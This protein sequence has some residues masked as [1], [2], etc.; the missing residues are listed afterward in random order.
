M[1]SEIKINDEVKIIMTRD[2]FGYEDVLETLDD[3]EFV[4]IVTYN[5]SKE[6]DDLIKK[7]EAFPVDKDVIIITNIPG[8]F[9]TYTSSF[10]RKKAKD[11]IDTYIERLNPEK[12]DADIK[13]FFNFG[14][15]SKIIM[16]DKAAYIG[17]ANF[18]DESKHNNECGTIIKDKRV[19]KDINEIFVQ[20]QIDEA[21]PYYS[22][23]FMKT[24]VMISNLLTQAEIY[25]EEFHY[26]FYADSGHQH[27]GRGDEYRGF[28]AVLSPILVENLENLTYSIE[29]VVEHLNENYIYNDIFEGL[30][31]KICEDIR[32]RVEPNSKLEEF[33]RFDP[34]N[35]IQELFEEHLMEGNSESVDDA[36]QQAV[37]DVGE[38]NMELA[39]AIYEA[40]LECHERL[41]ALYEFLLDLLRK[42]ETK[43]SV[44]SALDNT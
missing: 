1:K 33:S 16:T 6:S 27:H 42:V 37:N 2:E 14:N 39:E 32:E 3:A 23:K 31:L 8:R 28:D 43:R 21:V 25:Y 12:Y 24:Y 41:R 34:Q 36:A 44:N 22:S 38:I 9:K 29:E 35:K 17:S 11:T 13:T 15:H 19:I 30:D 10:A 4:R 18:S 26:S 40:A 5:I 7:L 20:M